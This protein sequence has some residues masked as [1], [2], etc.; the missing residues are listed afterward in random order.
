MKMKLV[1]RIPPVVFV[2]FQKVC[3]SRFSIQMRGRPPP[4]VH[5]PWLMTWAAPWLLW[6]VNVKPQYPPTPASR[7]CS[8][9]TYL[10]DT[11]TA[12]CL[13][14]LHRTTSGFT[15][16]WAAR[17]RVHGKSLELVMSCYISLYSLQTKISKY[18]AFFTYI[19]QFNAVVV[20]GG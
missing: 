20:N 7:C 5:D 14:A 17:V 13:T 10:Y 1:V 4:T 19:N 16:A 18:C 2:R 8:H 9:S 11:L 3:F 15:S 6:L 12:L